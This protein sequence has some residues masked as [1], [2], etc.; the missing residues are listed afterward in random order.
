[1]IVTGG[2]ESEPAGSRERARILDFGLAKSGDQEVSVSAGGGLLGTP[3]AMSPEQ[4]EGLPL[5]PASD[6]FALGVL[7]YEMFAGRSPFLASTPLETL[8]KVCHHEQDSVRELVADVPEELSR[9]IDRLLA[10]DP[11]SRPQSADE[12]AEAL[13]GIARSAR[14]IEVGSRGTTARKSSIAGPPSTAFERTG[15]R[16]RLTVLCCELV[17]EGGPSAGGSGV[18]DPELLFEVLPRFQAMVN[19]AIARYGGH[20]GDFQGHRLVIYF[21]YPQSFEDNAR[22]ALLT[23]LEIVGGKGMPA[24]GASSEEGPVLAVRAGL[25]AG[26]AV[27]LN[28]SSGQRLALGKTLDLAQAI[29]EQASPGEVLASPEVHALVDGFFDEVGAGS[30]RL[31]AS[32]RPIPLHRVVAARDVHSPVE[33]AEHVAPPVGRDREIDLLLDRLRVAREGAGQVVLLSGAWGAGKTRV[34]RA[35]RDRSASLLR[36]SDLR[37]LSA[38]GSPYARHSPFHPVPGLLTRWLRSELGEGADSDPSALR[39]VLER[40]ELEPSEV[41]PSLGPLLVQAS[42]PDR[43]LDPELRRSVQELLPELLLEVAEQPLPSDSADIFTRRRDA[44]MVLVFE[45]LQWMDSATLDVVGRLID[46]CAAAPVLLVLTC[47]PGFQ[48]PW[49]HRSHLTQLNLGA[50]DESWIDSLTADLSADLGLGPEDREA[51]SKRAAGLPAYAEAL[52]LAATSA[53]DT[54][55]EGVVD[56]LMSRLDRLGTAKELAQVAAL[57]GPTF[58]FQDLL[59]IWPQDRLSLEHEIDRL[60]D[61]GVWELIGGGRGYGFREPLLREAAAGSLLTED[62]NRLEKRLQSAEDDTTLDR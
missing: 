22:R 62:R 41:E 19:R 61:S 49:G 23:A 60:L 32:E 38:H 30:L 4:A 25:H 40:Y 59:A 46:L 53:T 56:L 13:E 15:E 21:G 57:L 5:G 12:V 47:R 16:R 35:L 24:A 39:L 3:R 28:T 7:F 43:P 1:M 10:K 34:V 33:I 8:G 42:D 2:E 6:L 44:V 9:L 52:A 48:S 26:P 31:N 17:V 37:W 55:P 14:V 54:P 36:D 20:L 51:I 45:G 11:A 58:S 50:L 18:L 27:V 29:Q